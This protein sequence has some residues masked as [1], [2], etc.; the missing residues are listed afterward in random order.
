MISKKCTKVDIKIVDENSKFEKVKLVKPNIKF[1]RCDIRYGNDFELLEI[2][3]DDKTVYIS[4]FI[5]GYTCKPG[6]YM[7]EIPDYVFDAVIDFIA[8][9]RK[10]HTFQ[11]TQSLN[12]AKGL[13]P[14]MHWLLHLP[15][16]WEEYFNSFSSKSR[17]NKRY[18]KRKLEENYECRWDYLSQNKI[19]E[20][21]I[22]KF[23]EL[24]KQK[25]EIY[26][27]ADEKEFLGDF[28][29]VTD[30]YVLYIDNHIK[31]VILYSIIDEHIAYCENLAYDL[32]FSNTGV[33]AYIVSA[34]K[35]NKAEV[36]LTR[37]DDIP[38]G[39]GII[40]MGNAGTYEIPTT[41]SETVVSNLLKGVVETTVLSKEDGAYTNYIMADGSNGL[42]FYA[43]KNGSTLS[44][45][46]AYLPL[47]TS[48]LSN[49]KSAEIKGIGFKIENGNNSVTAIERIDHQTYSNKKSTYF[50]LSGQKI[51]TPSKGIY[52]KKK[53]K[54]FIKK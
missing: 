50:T 36:T 3:Y 31:S 39:T 13:K 52:I 49:L 11:I 8:Q 46:K 1:N 2:K 41:Q 19:D 54:V 9:N 53:K 4:Y 15:N 45:N 35:P 5:E 30:A 22:K 21:F 17:Y 33:K 10:V 38:A 25:K 6:L 29:K 48:L 7:V 26:Y 18:Y 34:F 23:F 12:S 44:A 40:V 28:Y 16:T 42:G 37:V 20:D 51:I 43:V 47:L 14:I 32:D 27:D 24:K